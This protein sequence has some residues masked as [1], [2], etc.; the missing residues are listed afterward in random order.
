MNDS[1]TPAL[2]AQCNVYLHFYSADPL[3]TSIV[4]L[5]SA[6]PMCAF[7]VHIHFSTLLCTFVLYL[8]FGTLC[9]FTFHLPCE[10][11]LCI[12]YS[13]RPHLVTYLRCAPPQY[14]NTVYLQC[15]ITLCTSTLCCAIYTVYSQVARWRYTVATHSGGVSNMFYEPTSTLWP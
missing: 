14:P 7:I 5:H 10:Y 15:A 11:P 8:L 1:L 13:V 6:P 3:C 4:C 12:S 9:T 2:S